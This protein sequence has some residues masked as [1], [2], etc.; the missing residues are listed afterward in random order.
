MSTDVVIQRA[1][2]YLR[3]ILPASVRSWKGVWVAVELEL[4]DRVRCAEIVAPSYEDE[5]SLNGVRGLVD[6]LDD[7][8]VDSIVDWEGTDR[9][10]VTV[11]S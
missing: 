6:R 4:R 5:E 2:A 8:G 10:L 1:G 7:R 11:A 3:V 9:K